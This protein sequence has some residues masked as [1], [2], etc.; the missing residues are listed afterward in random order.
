MDSRSSPYVGLV[1]FSENEEPFFFGRD[2]ERRTV[3]FNLRGARLTILYG[4]AGVGKSSILGAGVMH[5]L[6]SLASE[7]LQNHQIPEFVVV[8]FQEWRDNPLQALIQSIG[9]SAAASMPGEFSVNEPTL[10]KTIAAWSQ[11]LR[12]DFLIILDQFED[13]FLGNNDDSFAEEFTSAVNDSTLRVNFLLS[14]REDALS[15]LDVFKGQIPKLFENYLRIEN[16]RAEAAREAI[17][18]PVKRYNDQFPIESPVQV[19]NSLVK[20]VIWQIGV[21]KVTSS[22]QMGRQ[23]IAMRPGWLSKDPPV[24]A[25]LLQLVMQS[26]W[27]EEMTLNSKLLRL[28]T[29]RRLG[30]TEMIVKN[31]LDKQMLE[32]KENERHVASRIFYHLVTPSGWKIALSV[33]DLS[34]YTDQLDTALEPVL[35]R[36]AKAR[37]L[38]KVPPPFQSPHGARFEIF[39]E[40]LAPAVLN[41]LSRYTL[42]KE[43]EHERTRLERQKS[44][45]RHQEERVRTEKKLLAIVALGALFILIVLSLLAAYA[46]SQRKKAAIAGAQVREETLKRDQ[47]IYYRNRLENEMPFFYAVMRGHT[48]AVKKAVFS[49]DQNLVVTVSEDGTARL[50]STTTGVQQRILTLPTPLNDVAFNRKGTLV[51]VASS[52]QIVLWDVAS[53]TS[54]SLKGHDANITKVAFSISDERFLASGDEEG[55]SI[56]WDVNDKQKVQ[57]PTR[58]AGRINDIEWNSQGPQLVTAGADS[59]ARLWDVSTNMPTIEIRH[60]RGQTVKPSL[61]S[62]NTAVFSPDGKEILT[63][64]DDWTAKLWKSRTGE[65]IN[66]FRDHGGPVYSGEFAGNGQ[67]IVTASADGTARLWDV[68][69]KKS[70]L[71]LSEH[72]GEVLGARF[73]PDSTRVIT[74]SKDRITRVWDAE[75]GKLIFE[76]KGH[77]RPVT[78]AEFSPNGRL[79]LTSSADYTAR[80]W[81]VGEALK[82][83]ETKISPDSINYAGPCP[84]VVR[85]AGKISAA[86]APGTVKYRFVQNGIPGAE[87]SLDFDEPGTKDVAGTY[88][89]ERNLSGSIYFEITSL[90]NLSSESLKSQ[91]VRFHVK[92]LAAAP[93]EKSSPTPSP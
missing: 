37:I 2:R 22:A 52:T 78:F 51:A 91:V 14:I 75:S 68:T 4:P 19:E 71:V 15:K 66:W 21:G 38:R 44:L 85:V 81:A 28:E 56:V 93:A 61:R 46:L 43:T 6:H 62:V 10:G 11:H 40:V 20:E 69:S 58:H 3:G 23:A 49:P 33:K 35:E 41:W 9:E 82:I 30:N 5:D 24:E 60:D 59:T 18:L 31:Y 84:T 26:L 1:P 65:F 45:L 54:V 32:L 25:P 29:L 72:S 63:T 74:W 53:G 16:L 42:A 17:E 47:E 80:V 64:G 83:T 77:I 8:M 89:M 12:S 88:R 90:R 76:L 67:T 7:N 27:D 79:V 48:G 86:G 87:R 50:W 55:V 57:R 92:C 39:H 13:Y 34:Y 73:S 70:L 36:L